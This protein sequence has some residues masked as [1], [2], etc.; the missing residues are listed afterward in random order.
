MTALNPLYT[1][2]NQI[3]E[4]ILEHQKLTKAEATKKTIEMLG[5]VGIPDPEAVLSAIPM[6]FP[7]VCVRER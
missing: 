1:I 6:S 7:A 3:N 2:G 4:V 5:M